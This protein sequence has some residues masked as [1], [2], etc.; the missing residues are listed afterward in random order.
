MMRLLE[1]FSV[2]LLDMNGTFMFG[3]DRFSHAEDFYQTYQLLGGTNLTYSEVTGH[4]RRCYDGM[5][6]RYRDP[7]Y[8]D[9]F[10]SLREGL[11]LFAKPP[12]SDLS[13]LECVFARHEIGFIPES[14]A[15][16]LQRLGRT[17]RLG[18]VTNIWASKELWLEEFERVGIGDIFRS[19]IFSSDTR[20]IK[21]SPLLYRKALDEIG[22]HP[23]EAL[24]IGD[25]LRADIEGAKTVGMTTVWI[26]DRKD[27][28]HPCVDYAVSSL[29][30]I[31]YCRV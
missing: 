12:E 15:K 27:E 20:S 9:D 7:N 29:H 31:E 30:D 10:P 26:T 8:Y 17:Q 11:Q 1:K 4:I 13:L 3:E 22:C 28:T 14:Y 24:F 5:I 16:L 23:D 6:A 19:K 21:P 25:S 18:L 2:L